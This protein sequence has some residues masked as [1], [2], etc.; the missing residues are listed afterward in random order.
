MNFQHK[1][2]DICGQATEFFGYSWDPFYVSLSDAWDGNRSLQ[3]YLSEH[4]PDGATIIDVG[5]NIGTTAIMMNRTIRNA[6]IVAIEPTPAGFACLQRNI[7]ANKI[8]NCNLIQAAMGDTIGTTLFHQMPYIAG[9][10]VVTSEHPTI[11][12]EAHAI[13]VDLLTI[14]E[15]VEREKLSRVDFI[16]IDVEGFEP[17]VIRGAAKTIAK[18]NPA[19]FVEFNAFTIVSFGEGSPRAF[20]NQLRA[21]F[22]A[23]AYD[24]AGERIMIRTDMDA[25]GFLSHNM[26]QSGCVSDLI[27]ANELSKVAHIRVPRSTETL[28]VHANETLT[29]IAAAHA[30]ER[31]R[32]DELENSISWKIT[33]PLRKLSLMVR[34]P[35]DT[36]H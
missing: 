15:V 7:E 5:A 10:H 22:S 19:V 29:A 14:D 23:I 9:S 24:R 32:A 30:A 20:L 16:K 2:I 12:E 26:T 33:K 36:S 13:R 35:R 3:T 21:M 28:P 31:Q 25:L 8:Q 27:C 11:H 17:S 1:Q 18:F 4:V 6:H 34:G